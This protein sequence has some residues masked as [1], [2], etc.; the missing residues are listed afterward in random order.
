MWPSLRRLPTIWCACMHRSRPILPT[1]RTGHSKAPAPRCWATTPARRYSSGSSAGYRRSCARRGAG[2]SSARPAREAPCTWTCCKAAPGT[3]PSAA[4]SAGCSIRRSRPACCTTGR[5][6][7]SART[8]RPFRCSRKRTRSSACSSR[9]TWCSRPADGGTRCATRKPASRGRRPSSTAPTWTR[10]RRPRGA[11][12]SPAWTRP[13]RRCAPEARAPA[14]GRF[15]AAQQVAIPV[16]HREL[17]PAPG[18]L[19]EFLRDRHALTPAVLVQ[20]VQPRRHLKGERAGRHAAALAAARELQAQPLGGPLAAEQPG[21]RGR[22]AED[23]FDREA[24]LLGIEARRRSD[25]VH[26]QH[27]LHAVEARRLLRIGLARVGPRVAAE[28]AR[29]RRAVHPGF[30]RAPLARVHLAEAPAPHEAERL[31]DALRRQ[32]GLVDPQLDAVEL[33]LPEAVVQRGARGFAHVALRAVVGVHRVAE[34]GDAGIAEE[35]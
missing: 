11:P 31:G 21:M 7:A 9:A 19:L 24:Q 26:R 8:S 34:A 14:S 5:W 3:R 22:L 16:A 25:V 28:P 32:V 6:T 10:W 18:L 15:A 30:A 12:A 23:V 27:R 13:C 20:P 17:A 1:Y 35:A 4:A 33:L 29:A 2:S